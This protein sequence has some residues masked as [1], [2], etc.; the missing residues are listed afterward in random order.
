MKK[1]GF[2][3]IEVL[4]AM[5]IMTVIFGCSLI[6]VKN[7]SAIGNRMEVEVFGNSL[8]NFIVASKKHCRDS[9]TG[10]YMY[11]LSGKNTI[12][13][14]CNSSVVKKLK[15]PEGFSDLY[16]NRAGS[17]IYIDNKG[18]TSDACT[19]RFRDRNGGAHYITVSVGTANVDF[20]G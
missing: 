3:L 9:G 13:L 12:Q 7:Y 2:T 17:K 10:G 5:S 6:N 1:R 15:M 20:K 4:M 18:F 11:F 14:S 16:I 8:V 19:I